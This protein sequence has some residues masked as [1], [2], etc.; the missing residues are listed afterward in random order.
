MRQS[1][2]YLVSGVI[3]GIIAILMLAAACVGV[4]GAFWGGGKPELVLVGGLFGMFGCGA[5]LA[6]LYAF[7]KAMQS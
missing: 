5:T 3:F 4:Y 1:E 2:Q 7:N 6:T